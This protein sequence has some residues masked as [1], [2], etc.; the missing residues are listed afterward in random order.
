MITKTA[1]ELVDAPNSEPRR[2]ARALL[3]RGR[4]WADGM[5][6]RYPRRRLT[7]AR[8]VLGDCDLRKQE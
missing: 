4:G 2:I 8:D 6:Q 1:Q 3:R 7:K 5:G